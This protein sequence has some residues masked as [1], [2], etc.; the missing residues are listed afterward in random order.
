MTIEQTVEVPANHRVAVFFDIPATVPAGQQVTVALD[1]AER[2]PSA[3]SA[4]KKGDWRRL[5]G[6]SAGYSGSDNI[7]RDRDREALIDEA[8]LAAKYGEEIAPVAVERAARWGI[9]VETL[10]AEGVDL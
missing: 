6:I 10:R 7:R 3:S 2:A 4:P 8:R 9:T 5:A 1:L